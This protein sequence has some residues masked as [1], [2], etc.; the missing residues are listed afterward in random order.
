MKQI[1][2]IVKKMGNRVKTKWRKN[3]TTAKITMIK[4]KMIK[5]E[6]KKRRTLTLTI[7]IQN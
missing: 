7:G 5:M 3:N 1:Q 2:R 6:K 4:K